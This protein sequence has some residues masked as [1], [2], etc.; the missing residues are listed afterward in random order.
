L[1]NFGPMS[2][3]WLSVQGTLS[4]VRSRNLAIKRDVDANP[5]WS[6]SQ[7]AEALKLAGARYGPFD[8]EAFL[9][10]FSIEKYAPFLHATKVRS[11]QFLLRRHPLHEGD[12]RLAMLF[13]TVDTEGSVRK[14]K[15]IECSLGFEPFEG[16]L[17]SLG[18]GQMIVSSNPATHSSH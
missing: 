16:S 18:C 15:R 2:L 4:R 3:K 6:E 13:W 12:T 9:S 11:V 1:F 5:A 10:E 8:K 7:I 17:M 14:G